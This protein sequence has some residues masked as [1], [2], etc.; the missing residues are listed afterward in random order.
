MYPPIQP[1]DG[2][3]AGSL[4]NKACLLAVQEYIADPTQRRELEQRLGATFDRE[5]QERLRTSLD[6]I[7][8]MLRL[9]KPLDDQHMYALGEIAGV[10]G[11]EV[12]VSIG[13]PGR[14]G[15]SVEG[16]CHYGSK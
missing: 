11:L 1:S 6:E 7:A 3:E 14:F 10:A 13:K 8:E 15:R 9:G 4:A 5:E 2:Y 16:Y 12:E